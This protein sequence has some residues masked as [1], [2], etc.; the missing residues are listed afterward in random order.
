MEGCVSNRKSPDELKNQARQKSNNPVNGDVN[1]RLIIE[2]LNEGIWIIDADGYTSFASQKMADI[3][4]YTVEEMI[5]KHLFEFMEAEEVEQAKRKIKRRKQGIR[6]QHSFKFKR[7]NG[8]E[9]H[10][11][12][13]TSPLFDD[14]GNYAGALAGVF[15][16]TEK[17]R[18]DVYKK[19][20][21]N[22][23]DKL[24]TARN[25]DDCLESGCRAI[26]EA[27]LFRRSILTLHNNDRDITHL[28]YFGLNEEVVEYARTGKAPGEKMTKQL[29]DERFRICHSYFIP[30]EANI[31]YSQSERYVPQ[32]EAYGDSNDAWKQ[33]DELFVPLRNNDNSI[34][35]WLSV[36]TPFNG[37]RPTRETIQILEE[38]LDLVAS[39]VREIRQQTI[40]KRE[41]S[42]L[43]DKNITLKQV[44]EHLEDQKNAKRDQIVGVVEQVI[45]PAF[46]KLLKN[47]NTVNEAYYNLIMQELKRIT[48]GASSIDQLR[49]RLS[50]REIEI[51][52]LIKNGF[53]SKEIA[54]TLNI[55]FTTVN[56]HRNAI[57]KKLGLSRKKVNLATFL[58]RL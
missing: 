2:N 14:E 22:L 11:T 40:L 19:A 17:R 44:L 53:T 6:E 8:S 52:D 41:R 3:L 43:R 54:E 24:R 35:G 48:A 57:R 36:D 37:K 16:T 5:G 23:L 12:L 31:D 45:I 38:I 30:T 56:K 13:I 1:Y 20:R 7:K 32:E 58:K 10:T 33:N 18:T 47:D 4:G 50:P 21:L 39:K 28:G 51:C 26:F 25:I 27:E 29:T 55:S 42:E 15:D 9:I 34:E 46:T 49:T